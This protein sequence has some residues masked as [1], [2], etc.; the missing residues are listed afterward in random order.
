MKGNSTYDAIAVIES[1]S[2]VSGNYLDVLNYYLDRGSQV[3]QSSSL[4]L[5]EN[6]SEEYEDRRVNFLLNNILNP[7]GQKVLDF[8]TNL[9]G[10]D[11]CFSTSMLYE[12]IGLLPPF[13]GV[14]EYGMKLHLKGIE[15]DF[16]PE[17]VV[18]KQAAIQK[19]GDLVGEDF[20]DGENSSLLR[21]YLPAFIKAAIKKNSFSY[22]KKM[23]GLLRPSLAS[24]LLISLFM[25][26]INLLGGVLAGEPLTF[27]WIWLIVSTVGVLNIFVEGYWVNTYFQ[28]YKSII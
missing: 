11:F 19:E 20:N 17:A 28:V 21:R 8:S 22:L 27:V 6:S 3:I 16:A 1:E 5:P 2:L 10:S 25:T 9:R 24:L 26:A 12:N 18:W 23:L 14:K 15:I 4:I 7:K 13:N